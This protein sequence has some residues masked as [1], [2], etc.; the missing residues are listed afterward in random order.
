M[1]L[2]ALGFR[3][4]R[5]ALTLLRIRLLRCPGVEVADK[6]VKLSRYVSA[7]LSFSA[8]LIGSPVKGS[9]QLC[10]RGVELKPINYQLLALRCGQRPLVGNV[11]IRSVCRGFVGSFRSGLRNGCI[12]ISV[13]AL[14]K[15]LPL[16]ELEG[17]MPLAADEV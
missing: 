6:T 13:K 4:F 5:G 1:S 2:P 17:K 12:D 3:L 9:R 14:L 15:S 7:V 11:F 8:H 16:A 10:C